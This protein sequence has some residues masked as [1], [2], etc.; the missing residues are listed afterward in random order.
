MKPKQEAELVAAILKV[1]PT[2]SMPQPGA[3]P[4]KQKKK[5]KRSK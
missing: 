5:P 3:Q 2:A 1:K 4:F